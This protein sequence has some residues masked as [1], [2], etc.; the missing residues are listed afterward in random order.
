[1]SD[2]AT[3]RWRL[4][5]VAAY[6]ELRRGVQRS[7]RE[8]ILYALIMF[9]FAYFMHRANEQPALVLLY[10][11]L[12]GGELFVG[13]VKW[14]IPSAE[15]L[16]LDGLVLL[17][18]AAL[19]LG[20]EYLRFQNGAPPMTTGLFLGGI[21]LFFAVGRF[22]AYAGL[23]KLFA[24][25]PSSEHIAWF[26]D[27]VRDILTSDPHADPLALDLPTTP[28]WRAKLIGSTVFFVANNGN[29]VWVAGPDDFSLQRSRHDPGTGARKALLRIQ[30]E[31]YPEFLLSDASWANYTRWTSERAGPA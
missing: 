8:N 5:N 16:I 12:A 14:V 3:M 7:G 4:Q 1:M 21:M 28:H 9:G 2:E 17:A 10:A 18:F 25:R 22:R 13:L 19:N 11:A 23:R 30:G 27:L 24:E 20:R 31:A 29:S 26:D 15:G 6:R